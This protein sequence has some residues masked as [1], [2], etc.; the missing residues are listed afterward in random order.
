MLAGFN[1]L[2][3]FEEQIETLIS[4]SMHFAE[5]PALDHDFD[6]IF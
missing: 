6:M 4:P 5:K 3:N 2:K 1:S